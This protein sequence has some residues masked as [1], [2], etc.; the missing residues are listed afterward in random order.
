MEFCD[1]TEF[2][3]GTATTGAEA[4]QSWVGANTDGYGLAIMQYA[5]QWAEEMEAR[6][7]RGETVAQCA[8]AA[9]TLVDERPGFGI[10]GFMYGAAVQMLAK[11]WAHGEALRQWHNVDTAG[12]EQGAQANASGATLNPA[13]LRIG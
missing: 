11:A 12:E 13:L 3:N 5:Q 10:T 7:A 6:V 4:W 8:K 2:A 9:G 1:R